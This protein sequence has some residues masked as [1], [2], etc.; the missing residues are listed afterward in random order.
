MSKRLLN[1]LLPQSWRLLMNQF[2]AR[3]QPV[4]VGL[5]FALR[6]SCTRE[7][8]PCCAQPFFWTIAAWC[9]QYT[10]CYNDASDR[11]ENWSR[12]GSSSLN[13]WTISVL[14]F[15]TINTFALRKVLR[16]ILAK[17]RSNDPKILFLLLETVLCT[18]FFFVFSLYSRLINSAVY[19]RTNQ[20]E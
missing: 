4:V 19:L 10:M 6:S 7:E 1:P 14:A 17:L 9:V 8:Q 3:C 15:C 5:C 13:C 2:S 12:L 18:S 11:T 16:I 20:S